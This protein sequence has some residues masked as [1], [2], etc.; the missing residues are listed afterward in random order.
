M[1]KKESKKL[2]KVEPR[3]G[4]SPI[5]EMERSFEDFFIRPFPFGGL[6]RLNFI[7][8]ERW[9]HLETSERIKTR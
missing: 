8:R 2:R 3:G 4:L 1:A 5:G 9:Y 6:P 7:R